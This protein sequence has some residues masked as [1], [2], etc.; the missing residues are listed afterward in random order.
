MAAFL[1]AN[2]P[3]ARDNAAPSPATKEDGSNYEWRMFFDAGERIAD[4]DE[5]AEMLDILIPGYL[6]LPP[7]TARRE[8]RIL[9]AQGVQQLARGTIIANFTPEAADKISDWE[10]EVL[11]YGDEGSTDPFGWGEDG[12]GT[13]GV[14]NEDSVDIWSNDTPLV[15]I[16]TSYIPVTSIPTPVSDEGDYE[17]VRNIIWLRPLNETD[18]LKSLSRIGLISFGRPAATLR[19]NPKAL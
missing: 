16:E 7:G 4:A 8:A 2:L 15:L 3:M 5:P 12:S 1:T 18:F 6:G 9:F 13:L 19:I 14:T 17:I 11:N 10:W